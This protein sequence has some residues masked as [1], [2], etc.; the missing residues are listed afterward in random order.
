MS[1]SLQVSETFVSIQGE[2]TYAGC[3]CFFI[4]LTGCNLRCSYCDTAYAY[5]GGKPRSISELVSE[6]CDSGIGL[7]EV[8]GGE[9]LIQSGAPALLKALQSARPDAVVLVETNG[10][11][12]ISVVPPGVVTI[13]DIKC[14]AS[15]AGDSFDRQNLERVRPQDEIKFVIGNRADFDWAVRMVTDRRLNSICRAVLF[16]PAGNCLPAADLAG[17]LLETR[18][19]IRLNLQLHKLIGV[20]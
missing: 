20:R 7:V 11:R 16:S 9:P 19:S 14:P 10:S 8:T 4:R 15:G 1:E 17:W 13:M 3:P 12:D 6:Y 2:S 18:L 5:A